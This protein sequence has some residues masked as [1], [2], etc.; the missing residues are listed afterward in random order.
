MACKY[1]IDGKEFDRDGFLG[2][3]KTLDAQEVSKVFPK[4]KDSE[5]NKVLFLEE[6]QSDWGQKGKKEGFVGDKQKEL[7][8]QFKY[9][10]L[11]VNGKQL[12]T[13]SSADGEMVVSSS[14]NKEN[15][16]K[17]AE[18]VARKN[19]EFLYT[20]EVP[21][22]PFVTDTNAWVK[23]GLKVALKE[24]V[25]QGVDKIGWTTGEQQNDR[26]DLSKQVDKI[27]V[28]AVDDVDNLFFVGINLSNGTTENL[29]VENGIVRDGN[30]QGQRLD[31][32]VGKDYAEKIL[33][34]PKGESTTLQ[35][36][37]LKV[38]GKGMKGFYG[39]PS[40]GSLGIVGNVAK[41]L[42]KQ[43]PKTVEIEKSRT[44][45]FYQSY[46]EG[47]YTIVEYTTSNGRKEKVFNNEKDAEEFK[48]GLISR[49]FSIQHSIDITPD[50]KSQVSTGL[51]LFQ[52][53]LNNVGINLITNGFTYK[54]KNGKDV[55][56]LNK[57]TADDSTSM[58]EF[59]HIFL[60]WMKEN[61]P[62]M[63]SRGMEL[64]KNELGKSK[65]EIQEVIDYVKQTQPNL[66]G[67]DLYNEILTELTGR[68]GA[69]LVNSKKKSG[70][71]EWIKDFFKE[72]GQMLGILDMSPQE[73]ANMTLGEFAEKSAISLL[74]GEVI[75]GQQAQE[76]FMRNADRLP[77]TLAVFQRP[78]FVNLQ[79]KMVNPITVLQS[80][81]QTGIKQIEKELIKQVVENNFPGQKKISYDELEAS[82]RANIMPLERIYTSS[83]SSY[84]MD[85]LGDGNYGNATTIILNSPIE[86]GV[87]G[88]F[89]GDFKAS[90][91][92]NIKYIPKQLN[93]ST[94]VAVEEGYETQ[95]NNN[96]IYQY[97]GTAGTKEAVES[98]IADYNI[99]LNRWGVY[100]DINDPFAERPI[101]TFN[102]YEEAITFSKT[103]KNYSVVDDRGR[104]I[105]IKLKETEINKGMFGHIRVWQDGDIFYTAELQSDF[106]QKNNARK[107]FLEKLPEYNSL[108][109]E[110][111]DQIRGIETQK[112]IYLNSQV[113]LDILSEI[114]K[115][116]R[117]EVKNH[118]LELYD[119]TLDAEALWLFIDGKPILQSRFPGEGYSED[120]Q[121]EGLVR[122][123]SLKPLKDLL[124][125]EF[126]DNLQKFYD[127]K[128]KEFKDATKKLEKEF[129]LEV[130]KLIEELTPLEKQFI[131]S[132]KEW[133]KRMVR[134]TIKEAI[135]SEAT[136]LRFP[137]PYTIS[138]IEG[139]ISD[140]APYVNITGADYL[141][142]GD[143]I[144]YLDEDYT[145]VDSDSSNIIVI[146]SRNVYIEEESAIIDN[147]VTSRV[148]D[149]W[150]Y[151][152]N[153][154]TAFYTEE[155]WLS[156][157][158][159]Y[160]GLVDTNLSDV[161]IEIE[162]GVFEINIDKVKESIYE[163]YNS[164]YKYADDLLRDMGYDN[165]Y[166]SDG[167][168]FYTDGRASTETLLQPSEYKGGSKE[169][170][171][172][173]DDLSEEQ[174]T[175]ASKY[176][177]IAEI[178]KQER[179]NNF[180]V[181][182][183]E[184]GFD[185][186]ETKLSEEEINNPVVAFR[187]SPIVAEKSLEEVGLS[188]TSNLYSPEFMSWF[189]GSIA[190]DVNNNPLLFIK[191]SEGQYEQFS[192]QTDAIP[193]AL[194][195]QASDIKIINPFTGLNLKDV[196]NMKENAT[197]DI[198]P[199]QSVTK[200]SE[201]MYEVMENNKSVFIGNFTEISPIIKIGKV[202]VTD[203]SLVR[204]IATTPMSENNFS[205]VGA[206][207]S[208]L[209]ANEVVEK[210]DCQ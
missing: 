7:F 132:Q 111:D 92:K 202:E 72:I 98:W 34:T 126:A 14:E 70:I 113:H 206:K 66:Q 78:E 183:D 191:N 154:L 173:E 30:Y 85:N 89:G 204:E 171:S 185:W 27:D 100:D 197:L 210:V 25:A 203:E 31:N 137:T 96:N 36:N 124:G 90:Q 196:R 65:S 21:Q 39:S 76:Y 179:I 108:K 207:L 163:Y 101:K 146:K 106:Y 44:D 47:A 1:Y 110:L 5:G 149:D 58:H 160:S 189:S 122:N 49:T 48:K 64:V 198:T 40:E 74:K 166:N 61:K 103:N 69:E 181:V 67:E 153:N 129:N 128:L 175:V 112:D 29:E 120:L 186:Y 95:A 159:D 45:Q 6:V 32:I 152:E 11:E 139:Y 80:L 60:K 4:A 22:A 150:Y 8:N 117:V 155:E 157:K 119:G 84:G 38:G 142:V 42:F 59:N 26:Y 172:I 41:S 68:K 180:E 54:D 82:V 16:R 56:V 136:T 165:I 127:N 140:G 12:H 91:R 138:V 205:L 51:P 83:Y 134:E 168:Y 24:A 87:T 178:L 123:K 35:G 94:W 162:E 164:V 208:A 102:N 118:S 2:Y 170:F 107:T 43:E 93:D 141:D 109:R 121:R 19:A 57:D 116:P 104:N 28:E 99:I 13:Y 23:L 53:S 176:E 17:N 71:I 195:V 125:E 55:V 33:S 114:E 209:V 143:T 62:E 9:E 79:G 161:S 63:Y 3:V 184:N 46:N 75:K 200:I 86:H 169:S 144:E 194:S 156:F 20:R 177:Q 18:E 145:V 97:V 193:V 182:T 201:E 158:E 52:K 77:L 133:E 147:Y 151:V 199:T 190:V 10:L 148:D 130:E 73:V 174:A 15:A 50:L 105:G 88:H 135:L 115:N 37:D 188:E 81:N 131:A 167:T 187:K 192:G